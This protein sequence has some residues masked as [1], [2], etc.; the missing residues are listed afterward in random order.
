[1][2]TRNATILGMI[3]GALLVIALA[4]G[5]FAA[6]SFNRPGAVQAQPGGVSAMRQVTVIGQGEVKLAPDQATVQ[7]GVESRANTTREALDQNSAQAQAIMEQIK[8]LGVEERDIQTSGFNIY[9]NYSDNGRTVTGYTVSNNVLV[10]IRNLDQAG[11]LLDQVVSA[12]ANRI[13]GINFGL[14]D[15]E[16]ALAQA[17]DAAVANARERAERLAQGSGA[18][19]GSV[20]VIS[21]N[22]GSDPVMPM[23]AMMRSEAL[24][25]GAAVPIEP[26]E[27]SFRARV[28]V[29]YELR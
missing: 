27:Q 15:P 19:I 22:I 24:D 6:V 21:E 16:S 20:L 2:E 17:R 7:I 3:G 25:A 28:Q 4:A 29:T 23:P 1:M 13:Y 11:A 14:S 18:S 10:T 9:A 5:A 26:G 8:Q 12:G